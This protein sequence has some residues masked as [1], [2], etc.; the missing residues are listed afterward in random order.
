MQVETLET[1]RSFCNFFA[2][3]LHEALFN[4][5]ADSFKASALNTHL[6]IIE[7]KI[8]AIQ[9]SQNFLNKSTDSFFDEIE[10]SIKNDPVIKDG[11][12]QIIKE[13]VSKIKN[14]WGK[15]HII[16][17]TIPALE[18][19]FQDY[20]ST[21]KSLLFNEATS[22]K[23][24][25]NKTISLIDIIIV[26]LELLGYPRS[27]TYRIAH[28]LSKKI[29]TTHNINSLDILNSFFDKFPFKTT[30]Y[31]VLGY[32]SPCLAK[33]MAKIKDWSFDND[34]L[35]EITKKYSRIRVLKKLLTPNNDL[36]PVLCQTEN[37][38]PNNA[39]EYFFNYLSRISERINF[40][41]HHVNIEMLPLSLCIDTKN[42]SSAVIKKN[43][44]PLHFTAKSTNEKLDESLEAINFLFSNRSSLKKESKFRLT[45]ALEYHGAAIKSARHEEQLLNLWSCLEGFVGMPTSS[46]S[47]ISFVRES[48][49]SS[50]S[51]QYPQR[52]FSLIA[53]KIQEKI[54]NSDKYLKFKDGNIN[55]N[56]AHLLI[57]E[58][59][60]L[61]LKELG[62]EISKKDQL[63]LYRIF[64][65]KQRFKDPKSVIETLKNH[66]EKL[67][68]QINRI[69]FNRNLI[70]HS[71]ESLPY[72]STLVEH[73]HIYVD[74]FLGSIIETTKKSKTQTISA[75]LDLFQIHEK[76]RSN[77]LEYYKKSELKNEDISDWVFGKENILKDCIGIY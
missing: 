68:W 73:L 5:S 66:R 20:Y 25:K 15:N 12:K 46:E 52:L 55:E 74:C 24:S 30:N 49:L 45:Q 4:Y 59:N 29:R 36:E 7:L 51:L 33:T 41:D 38:C 27:N 64:E 62:C 16:S 9:N 70:T 57:D 1:Q 44:S 31:L 77:E 3:R 40:I 35:E 2:H 42:E 43:Y 53:Q 8:I 11:K 18:S 65:L 22:G 56:L 47:K 23:Y 72:L 28:D 50:L 6:R 61:L 48:I 39:S 54:N 32:V 17:S 76:I 60:K 75:V 21:A 63:L 34:L 37:I 10:W 19:Q 67:S 71:A 58:K 13:L 14:D 26:E 69:Y